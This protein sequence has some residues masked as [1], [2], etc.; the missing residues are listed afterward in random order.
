[1]KDWFS[2]VAACL[3]LVV[4]AGCGG[5]SGG[6]T[7]GTGGT[8]GTDTGPSSPDG[9]WL[10][11]EPASLEVSQYEG[12]SVPVS[13]T[14][15][16]SKTF[17]TPFNVAIIDKNGLITTR[18]NVFALSQLSYRAVL[19]TAANLEVGRHN[20]SLEV[21]VCEDDPVTCAKPL[22]GS[23]WRLALGI[24]VKP[25]AEAASR[26]T[27]SVPS[28]N[29][30]KYAEES[31]DF[32][33][34]AQFTG[35]LDSPVNIGFY[36]PGKLTAAS[37]SQLMMP[38]GGRYIFNLSTVAGSALPVGK[39]TSN[40]QLRV[41]RD[42]VDV[43]QSPVAGSPWIVP[44]AVIVKSDLNL[45]PLQPVP[46][47][48][49]WSTY[50]GNAKHTGFVEANF[51]PAVFSR[52]WRFKSNDFN[53]SSYA[54]NAI[55]NGRIFMVGTPGSWG[56]WELVALSED[57]GDVAWRVNLKGS[58]SNV[59]SPAVGN[60]RVYVTSTAVEGSFL[61]V[62]DQFTGALIHKMPIASAQGTYSAPTIFGS[63]AYIYSDSLKNFDD[64]NGAFTWSGGAASV[65]WRGWT[66]ST[67]GRFVYTYT[68]EK[69]MLAFGAN[70]G[71]LAFSI[72][73]AS[74]FSASYD[75]VPVVLTDDQM[76]I[77]V[78]EN[79]MAFD[80]VSRKLAWAM[81]LA[82]SGVPAVGNGVVYSFGANG[83]VLEAREPKTGNLL[84]TSQR[85]GD[86]KF[87][88]V[89]VSRNLAF[90]SSSSSTVAV[91]LATHQVVWRYPLGG[92]MAISAQGVLTIMNDVGDL[93]A[94]NL[95]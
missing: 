67:D 87:T 73:S 58:F 54:S 94:V 45:L 55:D 57:R 60:G 4:L 56:G 95:R 38:A 16:S 20:T 50:Q 85:L 86:R 61:W 69:R 44:L 71:N 72:G 30:T 76:G 37:T 40:L 25:K 39:H 29:L 79:L 62:F 35:E 46:G 84:W 53:F 8:G 34:E 31:V 3:F 88:A 83:S 64:R 28:V 93:D 89:I 6:S 47:L 26:M 74:N 78:S 66:P 92:S 68:T 2:R 23:P 59:S 1:M 80:L 27:L 15:Y 33:I 17:E 77:V 14:A 41:C 24:Q 90:V 81:S 43:C 22:P 19:N 51:D 11:F 63:N 18:V 65:V 52:R 10:A 49:A 91:D 21:R 5:G 75:A 7:G 42:S 36:D 82:S 9:A 13:V 32:S 12:E 70:D 48:G